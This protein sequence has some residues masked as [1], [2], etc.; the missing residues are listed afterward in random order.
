M[1]PSRNLPVTND[2]VRAAV[3]QHLR[4]LSLINDNEFVEAVEFANDN[5]YDVYLEKE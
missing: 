5:G 4:S 2:L 3:E 1:K